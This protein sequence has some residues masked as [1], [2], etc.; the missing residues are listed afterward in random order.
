MQEYEDALEKMTIPT[1]LPA[2]NFK[3][4]L[5]RGGA[6]EKHASRLYA[7]FSILC[8]C[9]GVEGQGQFI[10]MLMKGMYAGLVKRKP[11]RCWRNKQKRHKSQKRQPALLEHPSEGKGLNEKHKRNVNRNHEL[12][13]N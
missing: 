3:E 6:K 5:K 1:N 11:Y 8:A 2:P 10:G 4:I 9:V 13:W 12:R 7:C